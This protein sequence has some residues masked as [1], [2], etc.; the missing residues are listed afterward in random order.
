MKEDDV[1]E[2]KNPSDTLD[3]LDDLLEPDLPSA[4]AP[5]GGDEDDLLSEDNSIS[6]VESEPEPVTPEAKPRASRKPR[7][8]K[9]ADSEDTSV[10]D[11]EDAARIRE[12][13]ARLAEPPKPK[14]VASST[15]DA[16]GRPLPEDQLT[17]AQREIRH[18]EDE[19][20]KR[21]A[22]EAEEA[23]T[24]YV[25]PAEGKET[26]LIHIVNDGL[27]I[28]GQM[29]YRGQEFEFEVGGMA[30]NQTVDRTGFSYLSLVDDIDAQYERWGE[31]K[32]ARGPWRGRRGVTE[33]DIPRSLNTEQERQQ[34]LED[35]RAAQDAER[36]RGR[37]APVFSGV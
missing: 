8:P 29:T 5:L 23:E 10:V 14:K 18:L 7:A 35:A 12:L 13:Q 11:D 37:A 27:T 2:N 22:K 9:E 32:F 6:E 34:W 28:N 25:S 17:P 24:E 21:L 15:H 16:Q 4:D 1:A 26:L 20:A 36:R 19:L 3:D 30:W 33:K 31:Q